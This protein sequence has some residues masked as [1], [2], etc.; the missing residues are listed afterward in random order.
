ML[1]KRIVKFAG[2]GLAVILLLVVLAGGIGGTVELIAFNS[3]QKHYP[4]P[5]ELIDVDEIT[6]HLDCRGEGGPTVVVDVG[7]GNWSTHWRHIQDELSSHGRV[8]LHDRP[9]FGWSDSVRVRLT[10][11]EYAEQLHLLLQS[12][13]EEPPYLFVGHSLG[14]YIGRF[15]QNMYPLELAGMVL[16]EFRT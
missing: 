10:G 8:C 12:A 7:A 5:G 11:S 3:D 1:V 9:G 16:V 13:G 15:Y 2:Y 6:L 4:P 14:G